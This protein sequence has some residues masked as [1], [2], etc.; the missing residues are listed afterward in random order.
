MDES[1]QEKREPVLRLASASPRRRQ[2]LELIG[3][4][5]VVT[6]ADID[7]TPLAGEPPNDYVLRLAREKAEA[8]WERHQDL[9]VLAADTTVVVDDEIL[10]KPESEEDAHYMLGRLSGRDHQ[11]HTAVAL[12]T[13]EHPQLFHT[14][15]QVCFRTL[16]REEIHAYWESGEP[17]GKAGAYAIQGLGAVFIT[18][19]SG[20]YTGVMGLPLFETAHLLKQA[21]I[22]VWNGKLPGLPS[23]H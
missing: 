5:H 21:G 3:V 14:S 9:P 4:P 20:T 2:L 16:S 1:K 7:E 8:V 11:V 23:D 10:G 19:I 12:W 22:A 17:Q 6:P 13:G 15:T 18:G